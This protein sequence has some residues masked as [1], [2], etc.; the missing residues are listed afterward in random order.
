MV[1][2]VRAGR[3]QRSAGQGSKYTSVAFGKRCSQAGVSPSMG[4]VGDCY[5]NALCESF[6]A[7]LEL[8]PELLDQSRFTTKIMSVVRSWLSTILLK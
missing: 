6:Y 3:G 5:D 8:E 7:S 1:D 4:S 2:L